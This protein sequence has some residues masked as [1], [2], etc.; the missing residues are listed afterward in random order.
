[1][2]VDTLTAVAKAKGLNQSGL[3]GLAGVSRQAVSQWI[4]SG[5]EVAIRD[6]TLLR[7][8]RGLSVP[9]EALLS[10]PPG[11]SRYG[12]SWRAQF[13]WDKLYPG[14]VDFAL[15]LARGEERALA[16]LVDVVGLFDAAAIAGRIVWDE[17]SS[18]RHRLHPAQR[19]DMT[20]LWQLQKDLG[21][22]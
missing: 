8:G 15:A 7:L 19:D 4:K 22:I 6:A 12:E 20:R 11:L 17:F 18:Y 13:L 5:G 9:L 2:N 10:E 3:A 14:V 16:R 1:M 21:L